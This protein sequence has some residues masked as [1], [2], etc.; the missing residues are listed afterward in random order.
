MLTNTRHHPLIAWQRA[1]DL[2]IKLH[3]LALKH[4][5][6]FEKSNSE[7]AASRGLLGASAP[8]AGLVRSA[9][10]D[11]TLSALGV[12]FLPIAVAWIAA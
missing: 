8:L 5:P 7:A 9:R 2:F 12:V 10:T 1:D 6:L 4:S 11:L 3:P